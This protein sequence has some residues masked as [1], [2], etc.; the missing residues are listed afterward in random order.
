VRDPFVRA[1]VETIRISANGDVTSETSLIDGRCGTR[2]RS[3]GPD[4]LTASARDAGRRADPT[5]LLPA[6]SV[7]WP[8]RRLELMNP[9]AAPDRPSR[10]R[11]V[12]A[13]RCG[14]AQPFRTLERCGLLPA[15]PI[16][17]THAYVC[18]RY[19]NCVSGGRRDRL[20]R[21]RGCVSGRSRRSSGRT[22]P[23]PAST[24]PRRSPAG[25]HLLPP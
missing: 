8:D 3:A 19:G 18:A 21:D 14:R 4:S 2:A 24:W 23:R 12:S 9:H 17:Q 1:P 5:R 6:A 11:R 22:A 10:T 20:S 13:Q 15:S 7:A 25:T 16:P